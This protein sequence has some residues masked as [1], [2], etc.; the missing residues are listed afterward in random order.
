MS[1]FFNPAAKKSCATPKLSSKVI[2]LCC[3]HSD[4]GLHVRAGKSD[5]FERYAF[6]FET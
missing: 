1:T 4:T 6:V 2:T 5:G 3:N